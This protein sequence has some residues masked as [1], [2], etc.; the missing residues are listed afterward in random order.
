MTSTDSEESLERDTHTQTHRLRVVDVNIC[1]RLILRLCILFLTKNT[2]F[3]KLMLQVC[4]N[5]ESCQNVIGL[6][7]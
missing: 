4:D 7:L 1:S 2:P 5:M 6:M 3:S